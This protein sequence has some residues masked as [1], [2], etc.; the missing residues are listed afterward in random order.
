MKTRV[1]KKKEKREKAPS[2]RVERL[3]K[4]RTEGM[5]T[6]VGDKSEYLGWQLQ[7]QEPRTDI[8]YK[9]APGNEIGADKGIDLLKQGE[10]LPVLAKEG[11]LEPERLEP[12]EA[13]VISKKRVKKKQKKMGAGK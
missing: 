4:E 11:K 13:S 12:M 1:L 5:Y 6:G 9:V 10:K 2:P 7:A 3:S 8:E